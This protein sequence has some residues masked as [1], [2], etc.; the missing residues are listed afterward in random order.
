MYPLDETGERCAAPVIIHEDTDEKA[1]LAATLLLNDHDLDLWKGARRVATLRTGKSQ[2]SD[3]EGTRSYSMRR[4][5]RLSVRSLLLSESKDGCRYSRRLIAATGR[6]FVVQL[7]EMPESLRRKFRPYLTRTGWRPRRHAWSG[8]R[9]S[10]HD[11]TIRAA[12]PQ[13]LRLCLVSV[14]NRQEIE[15]HVSTQS[16]YR[17]SK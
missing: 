14:E 13:L 6:T 2:G 9:P 10:S 11:P 1:T 16:A 4:L 17:Q 12:T 3:S 7:D 5:A 15:G 8:S